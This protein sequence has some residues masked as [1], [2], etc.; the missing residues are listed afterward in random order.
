[1]KF[2]SLPKIGQQI[3]VQTQKDTI[4]DPAFVNAKKV[5]K[6]VFDLFR[7]MFCP[8]GYLSLST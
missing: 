2:L 7:W 6:Y 3:A 1:M 8:H 5:V 4:E